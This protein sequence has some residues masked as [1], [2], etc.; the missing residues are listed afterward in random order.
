MLI[1]VNFFGAGLELRCGLSIGAQSG[2]RL[3]GCRTDIGDNH[4]QQRWC[5]VRRS[6][7]LGLRV[8]ENMKEECFFFFFS[9][10]PQIHS[11]KLLPSPKCKALSNDLTNSP[12]TKCSKQLPFTL[13]F[14]LRLRLLCSLGF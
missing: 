14:H 12:V 4:L 1:F 2:Q 10:T 5:G 6:V 8:P 9:K 7:L 13:L 3:E 11:T